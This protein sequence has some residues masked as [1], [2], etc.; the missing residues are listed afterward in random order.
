MAFLHLFL[1]VAIPHVP[2]GVLP[3]N[4]KKPLLLYFSMFLWHFLFP[5][6]T[7]LMGARLLRHGEGSGLTGGRRQRPEKA[8]TA[9][10][11][12]HKQQI[13]K[14]I[15]QTTSWIWVVVWNMNFIFPY[16]GNNNTK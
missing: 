3:K 11:I 16:I 1:G 7:D 2:F 4:A 12:H 10:Q 8:I 5:K 14:G 9:K 6:A 13:N 15:V